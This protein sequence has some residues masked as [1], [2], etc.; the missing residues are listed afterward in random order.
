MSMPEHTIAKGCIA[1]ARDFRYNVRT[2]SSDADSD[3]YD[4]A[5]GKFILGRFV[6]R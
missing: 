3:R 5:R 6:R 2:N 1:E 4:L